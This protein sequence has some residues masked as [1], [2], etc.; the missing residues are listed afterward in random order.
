MIAFKNNVKKEMTRN[1]FLAKVRSVNSNMKLEWQWIDE[2]VAISRAM[3]VLKR[4]WYLI[5]D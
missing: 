2:T 3:K 5:T 4:K 1:T